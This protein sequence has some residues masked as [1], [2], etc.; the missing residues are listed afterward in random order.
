MSRKKKNPGA[1]NAGASKTRSTAKQNSS[2]PNRVRPWI[3]VS[4]GSDQVRFDGR[5]AQT[6]VLLLQYGAAGFTSG[7]ASSLGWARRTSAYIHKLR[8]AG[9]KIHT[10]MQ[11]LPCGATVGA[12]SLVTTVT[13]VARHGC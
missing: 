11:T 8:K 1:C 10:A 3:E 13:V 6:L 9:L 5:E 7:Q 2:Q 4:W 12:Y